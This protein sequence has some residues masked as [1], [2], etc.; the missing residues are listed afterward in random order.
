MRSAIP[1][2]LKPMNLPRIIIVTDYR[3]LFA[4]IIQPDGLPQILENVNFQ[5]DSQTS[6]PLISWKTDDQGGCYRAL[7][8]KITSILERYRPKS[9]GLACPGPLCEPLKNELSLFHRETLVAEREMNVEQIS[10][11]NV[12]RVFGGSRGQIPEFA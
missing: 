9:W 10:V 11:R 5:F 3:T 7:A 1:Q 12:A 8:E 4:Y 6:V 2:G